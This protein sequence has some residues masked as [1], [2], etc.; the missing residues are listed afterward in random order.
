MFLLYPIVQFGGFPPFFLT[1]VHCNSVYRITE[2]Q[3]LL[4]QDNPMLKV[5]N[6]HL[7][8]CLEMLADMKKPRF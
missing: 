6:K 4:V 7:C 1:A 3:Q 2:L 5:W 8:G